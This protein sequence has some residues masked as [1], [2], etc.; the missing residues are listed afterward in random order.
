MTVFKSAF[1][2]LLLLVSFVCVAAQEEKKNRIEFE[3]KLLATSR[4]TTMEKEM[5]DASAEG[6]A[7]WK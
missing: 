3:Y 7:F 1:T 5:N 2:I 6:Y 4:T